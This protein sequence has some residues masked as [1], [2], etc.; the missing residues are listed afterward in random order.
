M[1]VCDAIRGELLDMDFV[2]VQEPVNR[3]GNPLRLWHA[4]PT[5]STGYLHTGEAPTA[6]DF[7]VLRC[8]HHL[9]GLQLGLFLSK[10]LR[11]LRL[12]KLANRTARASL[13]SA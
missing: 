4:S 1:D 13:P 8:G 10:F 7:P 6:T 2:F 5:G 9:P 3:N 12:P 11:F